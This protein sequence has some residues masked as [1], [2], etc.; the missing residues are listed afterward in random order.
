MGNLPG[1]WQARFY[2]FNVY[3]HE[4]EEREGGL[5]ARKSGEWRI[6]AA[7]IFQCQKWRKN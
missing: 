2:D 7:S 3:S 1:F 5:H 6:G 4:K